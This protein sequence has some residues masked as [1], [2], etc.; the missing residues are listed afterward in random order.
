LGAGYAMTAAK[1][2]HP[3]RNEGPLKKTLITLDP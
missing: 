1:K 2:C 3:E